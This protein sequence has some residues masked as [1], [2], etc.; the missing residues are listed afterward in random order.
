MGASPCSLYRIF[1]NGVVVAVDVAKSRYQLEDGKR[2]E[3]FL[4]LRVSPLLTYRKCR[5]VSGSRYSRNLQRR[6]RHP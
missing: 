1:R 5:I 2:R 6:H 4:V 3:F